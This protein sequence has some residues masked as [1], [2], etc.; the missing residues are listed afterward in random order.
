MS[1][2]ARLKIGSL[3]RFSLPILSSAFDLFSIVAH[4]LFDF[5]RK[6]FISELIERRQFILTIRHG[7][8]LGVLNNILNLKMFRTLLKNLRC[9]FLNEFGHKRDPDIFRDLLD[10]HVVG[11]FIQQHLTVLLDLIIQ[12]RANRELKDGV[13]DGGIS[14]DLDEFVFVRTP[15]EGAFDLLFSQIRVKVLVVKDLDSF[16]VGVDG[17]E[18][19]HRPDT[20]HLTRHH[21]AQLSSFDVDPFIADVNQNIV[22][23]VHRRDFHFH[24]VLNVILV[25]R[26]NH[27][28]G[29]LS[30]LI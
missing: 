13:N 23:R 1:Y 24:H 5:R 28:L 29:H 17:F 30:F 11:H 22:E 19:I 14:H 26:I 7:A 16:T 10:N 15:N 21:F 2:F 27:Q 20:N 3:L 18:S 12:S 8:G 25:F 9:C 4:C 6:N